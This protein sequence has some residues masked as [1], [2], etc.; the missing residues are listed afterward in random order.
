M[1]RLRSSL[2]SHPV[3]QTFAFK[4][5]RTRATDADATN[6][7]TRRLFLKL[8]AAAAG[9]LALGAN[10]VSSASRAIDCRET[11]SVSL[12]GNTNHR[13]QDWPFI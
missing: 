10:S 1:T 13:E 9:G 12:T 11:A 7:H 6:G 3:K 4:S 2:L 5:I 8:T